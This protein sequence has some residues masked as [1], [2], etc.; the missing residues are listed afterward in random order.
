MADSFWKRRLASFPRSFTVKKLCTI[1]LRVECGQRE[2][3]RSS[4]GQ[5]PLSAIPQI[6]SLRI[7]GTP[8]A[9]HPVAL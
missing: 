4:L 7:G 5:N 1:E 8:A 9:P 2:I 3:L 6:D